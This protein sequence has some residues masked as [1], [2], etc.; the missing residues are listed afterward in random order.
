MGAGRGA[1]LRLLGLL[2]L[3]GVGTTGSELGDDGGAVAARLP[4]EAL[5]PLNQPGR[6][7][8]ALTC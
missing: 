2:G 6:C 1:G 3:L 7:Q 8:V 4:R 5:Q